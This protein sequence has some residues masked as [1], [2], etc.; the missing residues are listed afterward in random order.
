MWKSAFNRIVESVMEGEV[1]DHGDINMM[2]EKAMMLVCEI[3]RGRRLSG[4]IALIKKEIDKRRGAR[5]KGYR[6]PGRPCKP[7]ELI[8]KKIDNERKVRDIALGADS[9]K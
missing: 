8:T 5:P 2:S 1:P 3:V 4:E 7:V 6:Q 9:D